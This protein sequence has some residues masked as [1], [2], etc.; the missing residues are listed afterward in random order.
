MPPSGTI[1][2]ASTDKGAYEFAIHLR[3]YAVHICADT[4][5]KLSGIFCS[6]NPCLLQFDL[7][8]AGPGQLV[9]ILRFFQR[10]GDAANPEFDAAT[11]LGW[12][13][14]THYNVTDSQA[15]SR[16]EYSKRLG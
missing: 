8:K 2:L 12:H 4:Y 11:N 7:L 5:E 16:T 13:F 15:S 10:P 9:A 6:I 14:P 3:R 1:W